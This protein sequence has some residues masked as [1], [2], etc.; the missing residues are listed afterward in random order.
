[1]TPHYTHRCEPSGKGS[2]NY[3][4]GYTYVYRGY[5]QGNMQIMGTQRG[6]T[7]GVHTGCTHRGYTQ[8][9]H[10]GGTHREYTQGVHTGGTHRGYAQGVRTGGTNRG[11]AQGVH[12]GGTHRGYTGGTH[13]GNTQ[14]V[15]TG[16]VV[17]HVLPSP[18]PTS[19]S[20]TYWSQWFQRF[21]KHQTFQRFQIQCQNE[22]LHRK[23]T[24]WCLKGGVK[25]ASL[26][27]PS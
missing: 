5:I 14:G 1:M 25:V 18:S 21:H 13:R 8:G 17:F 7:Q 4:R 2:L 11:Y 26:L 12:T 16:F 24:M 9:V 15:H 20:M 22:S 6:Y 10:T 23:D 27:C 3:A 19:A